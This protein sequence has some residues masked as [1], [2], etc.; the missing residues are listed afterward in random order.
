MHLF[1]I[2]YL[3]S[4]IEKWIKSSDYTSIQEMVN[5]FHN[6]NPGAPNVSD[7]SLI[8]SLKIEKKKKKNIMAKIKKNQASNG[9]ILAFSPSGKLKNSLILSSG[10]N[11]QIIQFDNLII[12]FGYFVP[13]EPFSDIELFLDSIEGESNTWQDNVII[14]V[15]FNARNSQSTG[16]HASNSRGS[17]FFELIS[18]Y[19]ILL[20]NAIEGLFNWKGN[21]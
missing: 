7:Y 15:D 17:K 3:I 19:P 16:D 20:E 10:N 1:Y 11:W 9:G 14:E 6:V 18:K 4:G 13:S 12:G 8:D 5:E 21:Y 2:I